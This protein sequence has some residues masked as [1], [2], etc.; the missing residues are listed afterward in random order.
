MPEVS[1][2][3]MRNRIKPDFTDMPDIDP[4]EKQRILLKNRLLSDE[5]LQAMQETL[6]RHEQIIIFLNRRGF[7][8]FVQCEYCGHVLYCPN[9]DVALTYYK[10]SNDLHC[11]YCDYVAHLDDA[12]PKCGRREFNYAGYGTERLVEVLQTECPSAR[13]DRLDRDR[14]T[15]RGIQNVLGGFR[16]GD[17]DILI[18][19]QMIAKGHDIHNVT[20]VGIINADMTLH[21]PDFRSS[22]RT[23][24]L[25][26]QVSG[27]AGRGDRPGRVILQTLK[28]DHPAIQGIIQRDYAAFAV[29]ELEVRRALSYSPFSYMVMMRFEGSHPIETENFAI[30]MARIARNCQPDRDNARFLGPAPAPIPMLCGKLR[31]QLFL[32][33]INRQ[34]LHQWLVRILNMT[35]DYRMKNDHHVKCMIDVDPYDMM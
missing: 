32:R 15:T 30:E 1:I 35:S 27:R 22:E 29:Q 24:Q 6:N 12:C 16:N 21:L 25:L 34:T 19:T 2:V 4:E 8:N 20:M 10:Y 33:H 26:T 13:I 5:L 28:P 14:A 7:S 17:I 11:H 3:D 23:Y 9:C 18:G 31:F